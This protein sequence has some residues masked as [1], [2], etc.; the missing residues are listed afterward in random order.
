MKNIKSIV[1]GFKNESYLHIC[2]E[3]Q[4][5]IGQQDFYMCSLEKKKGGEK[6]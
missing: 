4:M 2:W 3:T 6:G 1:T 5:W